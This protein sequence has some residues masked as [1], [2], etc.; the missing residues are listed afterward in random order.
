MYCIKLSFSATSKDVRFV[1]DKTNAGET[2]RGRKELSVRTLAAQ[3]IFTGRGE[4]SNQQRPLPG[5]FKCDDET[6][7]PLA[8]DGGATCVI[9]KTVADT[10]LFFERYTCSL[11]AYSFSLR[12]WGLIDLPLRASNEG[13]LRPHVAR[14]PFVLNGPSKLARYLLSRGGLAWSQLRTSND[15]C[16]IVGVP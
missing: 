7:N 13:L 4:V 14:A 1:P 5:L 2:A 3:R 12:G 11:Q 8:S 6:S 16:F 10:F 9:L 15:H